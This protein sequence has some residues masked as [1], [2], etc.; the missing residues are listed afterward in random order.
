[1][2]HRRTHNENL[3]TTNYSA[4]WTLAFHQF[5]DSWAFWGA[6]KDHSQNVFLYFPAEKCYYICDFSIA[7]NRRTKGE[8]IY[9]HEVSINLD[10]YCV[11]FVFS[12]SWRKVSEFE[13][14]PPVEQQRHLQ[15]ASATTYNTLWACVCHLGRWPTLIHM[16][17][18]QH[19]P[20]CTL[21]SDQVLNQPN[22]DSLILSILLLVLH[23][24]AQAVDGAVTLFAPDWT[25][26]VCVCVC[27]VCQRKHHDEDESS[28][29]PVSPL[30]QY[31]T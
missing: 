1:M 13:Q 11:D 21:V 17:T 5:L 31:L 19:R 8:N 15:V 6:G 27:C 4:V 22:S 24:G 12:C 18:Y 28:A 9:E 23:V 20:W 14:E 26:R 7:R 16:E 3:E 29:G 2:V 10:F 30:L 25:T